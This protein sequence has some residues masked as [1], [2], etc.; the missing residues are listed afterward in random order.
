M[1]RDCTCIV[2]NNQ[3]AIN[4][5][6]KVFSHAYSI[7]TMQASDLCLSAKHKNSDKKF[8]NHIKTHA[9][10]NNQYHEALVAV[11]GHN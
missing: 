7:V 6:G 4:H 8:E 3:Y 9:Q 5:I 2:S 11:D 1:S 10:T